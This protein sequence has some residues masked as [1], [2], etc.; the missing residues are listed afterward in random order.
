[1]R[2]EIEEITRKL[3]DLIGSIKDT[4]EKI[5]ALNYVR[6]ELSGASPFKSEPVD[7]VL[8]VKSESVQAKFR[9]NQRGI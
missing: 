2:S 1:M 5:E 9:I 7:C 3:K 6:K 8:W 4:D